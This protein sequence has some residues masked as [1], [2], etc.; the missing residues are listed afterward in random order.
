MAAGSAIQAQAPRPKPPISPGRAFLLSAAVPGLAQARLDRS[1]GV[2]FAVAEAIGAAM[3]AKS[4]SE[5]RVARAFARDSTPAAYVIDAQTGQAARDTITGALR[6][7]EWMTSR[8][9]QDRI[10]ARRTHAEDWLAVIVFNH[11]FA[12]VDA[13]VAAHLWDL[14]TQ[15]E[16]RAGPRVGVISARVRW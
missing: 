9:T 2:L 12:G 13:F 10:R 7:A 11:L 16:F 6:V 4:L 15:I 14:P 1:T 5:L 8:Y 3:Y